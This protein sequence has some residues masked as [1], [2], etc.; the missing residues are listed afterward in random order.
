MSNQG[1]QQQQEEEQDEGNEAATA[2]PPR[3]LEEAGQ[4]AHEEGEDG[5]APAPLSFARRMVQA[6]R[7]LAACAYLGVI[8]WYIKVSD[9]ARER[10]RERVDPHLS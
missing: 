4:P 5:A 10:E 6:G 9:G 8:A 2:G 1:Q 7:A 3:Q